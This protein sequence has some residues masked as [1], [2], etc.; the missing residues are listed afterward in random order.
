[1]NTSQLRRSEELHV[2]IDISVCNEKSTN[3]KGNSER[4]G[5]SVGSRPVVVFLSPE[6][7]YK[8]RRQEF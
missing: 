1:M 3:R 8:L 2:L 5:R 6:G 4:I 7:K